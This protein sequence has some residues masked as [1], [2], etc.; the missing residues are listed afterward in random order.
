M[1]TPPPPF[2]HF[3]E[4]SAVSKGFGLAFGGSMGCLAALVVAFFGLVLVCS[5][6]F[7]GGS[8]TGE[9]NRR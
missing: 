6:A 9:T 1:S 3:A 4:R 8:P 7:S 2:D 5:G